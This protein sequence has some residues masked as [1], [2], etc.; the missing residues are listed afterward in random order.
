VIARLWHGMTLTET[1]DDYLAFLRE[2][3]VPDYRAVPGNISVHVMRR[4][5]GRVTHF[6]VLTHWTSMDAVRAFAG[7][8]AE[9][10]RYY[11]ED[12]DFLLG[13]ERDVVHYRVDE[14]A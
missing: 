1:A 5:E 13:F 6:L 12:T 9:R 4:V 7:A 11:P 14:A 3:A 2:R 10:A 8:Q